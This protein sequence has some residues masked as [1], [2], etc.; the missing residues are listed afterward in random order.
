MGVLTKPDLATEMATKNAVMDLLLDKRSKLKLGYYAVKNRSADDTTSITSERDA[1]ENAFFMSQPWSNA[2]DRC[3]VAALKTRLSQLLMKI[4]NQEFPHVKAD[5]TQKLARSRDQLNSMG[6]ARGDQSSQRLYLGRLA[7]R[8][9]AVAQDAMKGY[10]TGESIF[11][12][13][14]D[15]RLVTRI[16]TLCEKFSTVFSERGHLDVLEEAELNSAVAERPAQPIPCEYEELGPVLQEE[17]YKC[18][19]PQRLTLPLRIREIYKSSRG[20]ELGTVRLH[21]FMSQPKR[22]AELTRNSLAAQSCLQ[23]SQKRRRN[24]LR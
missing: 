22:S 3:G 14:Q 8:F 11:T 23:S 24:G 21:R 16:F 13:Y 2:R 6:P 12:E 9:Q 5:I 17:D 7:T 10:Y 20:P 1:S 18:P 4:S 15:M 19:R